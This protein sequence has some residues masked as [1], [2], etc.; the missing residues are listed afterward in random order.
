MPIDF[1]KYWPTTKRVIHFIADKLIV[2]TVVSVVVA[3]LTTLYVNPQ[4][5]P[6]ITS[7]IFVNTGIEPNTSGPLRLD[8]ISDKTPW[9]TFWMKN[10][11]KGGDEDLRFSIAFPDKIKIKNIYSNYDPESLKKVI[12][13]TDQK[14]NTFSEKFNVFPSDCTVQYRF[15][16][17]EFIKKIDHVKSTVVS[18]S[19][20]WT[21]GI[22]ITPKKKVT[23][24]FIVS[25]V[26]ALEKNN[27]NTGFGG[28]A[29]LTSDKEDSEKSI[30]P[31]VFIGGYN[32]IVM[33][34]GIF[35]LLQEK[36]IISQTEA[37]Q[38]KNA[39][40]SSK[41][42]ITF[43]GVNILKFCELVLNTLVSKN[44][45]TLSKAK[46][47]VEKSKKG[48]GVLIG[49]YNVVVL[50]VEILNA[51]LGSNRITLSEGQRVIDQAKA[52]TP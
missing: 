24:N 49:G 48:E 13:E 40:E 44:I 32:P 46:E 4:I 22:K 7:E 25:D 50:Q 17:D 34:N 52:K 21:K 26:F 37:F 2:P 14:D 9:V 51:L 11:G 6:E 5:Q 41:E 15:E 16:L 12:T 8:Y 20:N 28:V 3:Y 38:L 47:I 35:K 43:S 33:V 1:S 42:G 18:K 31:G 39:A 10:I 19:K 23:Y 36:N 27:Y 29:V 45:I 30:E